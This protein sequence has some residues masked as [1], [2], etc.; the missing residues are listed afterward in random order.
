MNKQETRRAIVE[1]LTAQGYEAELGKD[2]GFYVRGMGWV[3]YENARKLA[4][5]AKHTPTPRAPRTVQQPWGD[6][7]I[8]AAFSGYKSKA[9]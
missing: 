8:I 6:Y 9:K 4:G 2:G 7:A 5:V 3:S 1:A